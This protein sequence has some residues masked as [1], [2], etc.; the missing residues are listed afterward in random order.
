MMFDFP[1]YKSV[2]QQT[3]DQNEEMHIIYGQPP[4]P[5][6]YLADAKG[7]AYTEVG[8]VPGGIRPYLKQ[9]ERLSYVNEKFSEFMTA[10]A[11]D[12]ISDVEKSKLIEK[13]ILTVTPALLKSFY[14]DELK[15]IISLDKDNEAG[16]KEK[17]E[18]PVRMWDVTD[19]F[20]AGKPADAINA[21]DAAIEDM[22][23]TGQVLQEILFFKSRL[24]FV[25]QDKE[26]A[27][28]SLNTAVEAGPETRM[29]G[30]IKKIISNY[31][32]DSIPK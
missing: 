26:G 13:A 23:P 25:M 5:T 9:I 21:I 8:Y 32:S 27:L 20:E 4:F 15:Q 22:K 3:K 10:A 24:Q 6:V 31:F 7:R 19:L 28:K 16:L 29:A 17:Y 12:D 1:K 11:G 30:Q 2:P 18:L 14:R